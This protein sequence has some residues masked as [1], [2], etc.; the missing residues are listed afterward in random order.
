MIK[1]AQAKAKVLIEAL[2]YLQSFCRS[3]IVVKFGGSLMDQEAKVSSILKDIALMR[4]VG[5]WPVIVHGGGP[6]ITRAV[7]A[8]GLKTERVAGLRITSPEIMEIT[9]RVLIDGVSHQLCAR[10]D[11]LGAKGIPLNGR[12]S[13]FL[14]CRKKRLVDQ[15]DVDLGL[16][17]EIS[18]IDVE[19]IR[20]LCEGGIIPVVAPVAKGPDDRLFNV[21]ADEV[22][23]FVAIAASAEK[24]VF[25]SDVDGVMDDP[26]KPDSLY[27]S[28]TVDACEAMIADGRISGGMIPKIKASVA[29]VRE[30]VK[31]TH[32]INGNTEHSLL[33]EMFTEEGVG[34]QIML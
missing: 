15:P 20:R 18:S 32:I 26:K 17:G 28:L 3:F 27:S 29:A 23:V 9:Q 4:Q 21:N 31:K 6:A 13:N 30:G 22:A 7:D 14:R 2:P 8:A 12:G 5:L 33:L 25:L 24:I 10:L 1:E 11:K 19:L 16:V 34:T